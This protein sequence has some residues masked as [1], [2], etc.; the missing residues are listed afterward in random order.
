L[1]FYW[2]SEASNSANLSLM[3]FKGANVN[4]GYFLEGFSNKIVT[5]MEKE[6]LYSVTSV[7]ADFEEQAAQVLQASGFIQEARANEMI[8]QNGRYH[9]QLILTRYK[10]VPSSA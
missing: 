9:D 6:G 3:L 5:E 10:E 7:I 2:F 1:I 8:Y 4:D